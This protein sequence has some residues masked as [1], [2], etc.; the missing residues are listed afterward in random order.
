MPV[1]HRWHTGCRSHGEPRGEIDPLRQNGDWRYAIS[2]LKSR[3]ASDSERI[4]LW[5]SKFGVAGTA[6]RDW[7]V[8]HL[9]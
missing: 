7:F 2:F 5:C 8:A 3:P 6:A 1:D 4:I 9:T